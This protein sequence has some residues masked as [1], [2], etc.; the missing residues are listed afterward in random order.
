MVT[1]YILTTWQL[2]TGKWQVSVIWSVNLCIFNMDSS[3]YFKWCIYIGPSHYWAYVC[4]EI[5]SLSTLVFSLKYRYIALALRVIQT[6]FLF[7]QQFLF[8]SDLRV[9]LPFKK[10]ISWDVLTLYHQITCYLF[11][12]M[13]EVLRLYLLSSK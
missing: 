1:L 2:M 5:V 9:L 10:I 4:I 6:F 13:Q 7:L 12:I 11:K 3:L 8:L